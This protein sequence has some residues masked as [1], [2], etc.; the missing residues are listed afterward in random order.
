V[1]IA[2]ALQQAEFLDNLF[3]TASLSSDDRSTVTSNLEIWRKKFLV[4][5]DSKSLY[6]E[7]PIINAV[8]GIFLDKD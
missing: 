8:L 7:Q 2:S 6:V 3:D 5:S 4:R 1:A